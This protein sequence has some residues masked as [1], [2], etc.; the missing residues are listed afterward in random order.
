M[1]AFDGAYE[2]KDNLLAQPRTHT[3]GHEQKALK[4]ESSRSAPTFSDGLGC[5]VGDVGGVDGEV[6]SGGQ[7]SVLKRLPV[8]W[9]LMLP[10]AEIRPLM[11]TAIRSLSARGRRRPDHGLQPL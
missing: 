6:A 11:L 3:V 4:G 8:S 7:G 1:L 2:P 10:P 5:G 9:A